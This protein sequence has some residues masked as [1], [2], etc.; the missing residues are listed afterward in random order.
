[1]GVRP[2]SL[3]FGVLLTYTSDDDL[4]WRR[5][6]SCCCGACSALG[7]ILTMAQTYKC[8]VAVVGAGPAGATV[9]RKLALGG[10]DVLLLER[11]HVPRHK[12][13]AGGVT[14]AARGLLGVDISGV[15]ECEVNR[16]CASSL[17]GRHVS[18]EVD[19]PFMFTVSRDR[20]DAALW[21][22]AL[23]AGALGLDGHRVVRVENS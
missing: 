12:C 20:L 14:P 19:E 9:A 8:E 13:C 11:E 7:C 6:E 10:V 21:S 22:A 5:D 18:W 23:D 1:M 17:S 3:S 2:G 16:L 4:V 15:V